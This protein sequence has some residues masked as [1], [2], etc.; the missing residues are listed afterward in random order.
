MIELVVV[1]VALLGISFVCSMLEA[2]ILSVEHPYIQQLIDEGD[3]A[4]NLLLRFK[5]K[6]EEPIVAILVL[7]TISNTLGAAVSGAMA[8][9]IFGS[10]WIALFSAV[11]TFLVLTCS[12]IIPKT[13]GAHNWRMLGPFSAYLLK[14]IVIVMKPIHGPISLLT[15]MLR[16]ADSEDRIRKSDIINAIRIGYFQ[17]VVPP[18][19]FEIMKNLFQLHSIDVKS[20]M[21]PRIV[22]FWLSPELTIEEVIEKHPSIQFSR[23]PLYD[24]AE[25]TVVGVVLRRDIMDLVAKRRMN[26]QVKAIARPPQ[27]VPETI[28]VYQLL[29]QLIADKT[30]LAIV[31]DE[32]GGL[33]GVVTLEDAIETLLGRE[34][35]D[36]FDPAVDM[37][38]LA[39]EKGAR[40][41]RMK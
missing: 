12:E 18:S 6:I 32:Y 9:R 16:P 2:V 15:R 37:Q 30:H 5:E 10:Q 14:G 36:E 27:F 25:D 31:L 34:I 26:I 4:G 41:W 8:A 23:I 35:V 28:S 29:N 17:G 33:S 1:V 7:N 24:V 38:K 19:E 13:L 3:R 39:R 11:L 22:M 20:I 40:F 21:T